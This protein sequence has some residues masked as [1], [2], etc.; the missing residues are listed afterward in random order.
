MTKPACFTL[1][2]TLALFLSPALTQADDWPQWLG[3]E[4]NGIWRETGIVEAFSD[5]GPEVLWRVPAGHGYSSPTV[6]NG[7]VYLSAY[8]IEEGRIMS[9]GMAVGAS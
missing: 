1:S 9:D 6:A 8:V 3:P 4:R 2:L 5:K 7:K